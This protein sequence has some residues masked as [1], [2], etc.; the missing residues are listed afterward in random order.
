MIEQQERYLSY[1]T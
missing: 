1:S